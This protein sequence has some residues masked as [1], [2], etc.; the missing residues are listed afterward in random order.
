MAPWRSAVQKEACIREACEDWNLAWD[1]K[2]DRVWKARMYE[3][4]GAAVGRLRPGASVAEMDAAAR[5][6]IVPLV[7]EFEHQRACAEI[8]ASVRGEVRG[9]ETAEVEEGKEQVQKALAEQPVGTSR[10]EMER[11]RDRALE[12]IRGRTAARLDEK[13]REDVLFLFSWSLPAGMSQEDQ[14]KALAEARAEIAELPVGT[15]RAEIEKARD[16]VI[17]EYK[18]E[19][20]RKEAKERLI[21]AGLGEIYGHVQRL[22]QDWEFDKSAWSLAE[23]L[24]PAIREALEEELEGDESKE[25]VVKRVRRLVRQELDL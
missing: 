12:P 5:Q 11:T 1:M 23:E 25:E 7:R 2:H 9:A 15:P 19:Q 10:R 4:A 3:A 17:A 16:R 8:V 14:A 13:M 6:A 24:K 21:E 18:Q 20:D 22:E